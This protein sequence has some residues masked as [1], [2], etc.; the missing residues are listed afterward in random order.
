VPAGQLQHQHHSRI[1]WLHA[2]V[3]LGY[4]AF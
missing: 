4:G 3:G 1:P 2:P